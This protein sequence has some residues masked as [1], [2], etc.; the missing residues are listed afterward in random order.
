VKEE[1]EHFEHLLWCTFNELTS[2]HH[3]IEIYKKYVPWSDGW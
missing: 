1:E 3:T 2:L